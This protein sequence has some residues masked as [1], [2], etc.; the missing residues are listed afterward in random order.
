MIEVVLF[1]GLPYK[2]VDEEEVAGIKAFVLVLVLVVR[3]RVEEL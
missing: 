1:E 2:L 3:H